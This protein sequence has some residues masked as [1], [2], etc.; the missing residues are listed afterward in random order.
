MF[1][2]KTFVPVPM[3]MLQR[4]KRALVTAIIFV[5]PVPPDFTR[6][7]TPVYNALHVVRVSTEQGSTAMAVVPV[8]PKRATRVPTATRVSTEQGSTVMAVEQVTHKHAQV[9]QTAIR[10]TLARLANTKLELLAMVVFMILRRVQNALRVALEKERRPNVLQLQTVFVLK[11]FVR[12]PMAF[13]PPEQNVQH[14]TPL[15]VR[16]VTAVTQKTQHVWI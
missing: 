9:V 5:R 8:I 6:M 13:Q 1:V 3:A 2:L 12:A 11:T 16:P 10:R 7:V 4:E 14:M 15:F